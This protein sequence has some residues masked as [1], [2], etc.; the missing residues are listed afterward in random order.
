MV[1]VKLRCRE[2]QSM[3]RWTVVIPRSFS[4]DK[5]S[6]HDK[7][8]AIRGR[9]HVGNTPFTAATKSSEGE[10]SITPYVALFIEGLKP[11]LE[12]HELSCCGLA[13]MGIG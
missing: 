7:V 1:A 9:V 8:F 2:E 13:C 3:C 12:K 5:A 6:L 11:A 4:Q 10:K